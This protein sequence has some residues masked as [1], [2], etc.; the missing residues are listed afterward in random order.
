[1]TES[2]RPKKGGI[3]DLNAQIEMQKA[4]E[5]GIDVVRDAMRDLLTKPKAEREKHL[6]DLLEQLR[7]MSEAIDATDGKSEAA[8]RLHAVER[9]IEILQQVASKP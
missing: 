7:A 3:E 8:E 5:D 9:V 6:A 2:R 4:V 1:V